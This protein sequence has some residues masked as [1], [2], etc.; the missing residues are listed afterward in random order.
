MRPVRTTITATIVWGTAVVVAASSATAVTSSAARSDGGPSGKRVLA[1]AGAPFQIARARGT[2]FWTD[3]SDQTINR[4][5]KRGPVVAFDF[6]LADSVAGVEFSRNGRTMAVAHGGLST[7]LPARVS[8]VRR[9]KPAIHANLD[10]YEKNVNPDRNRT[11][12]IVSAGATPECKE[13]IAR[14]M[15][16]PA[17]YKGIK[18]SNPH[19]L[20]RL[21]GGAFAVADSGAN[22]ILR[23][24]RAGRISTI[25]LL[26][27]QPVRLTQAH[28]NALDSPDC[29]GVTYAFE[30]V[31]TDVEVGRRGVLWV[32][33][34]PGGTESADGGARGGLYRIKNGVVT[35]MAGGFLGATN[36]ALAG[37]RFYVT[38]F[39]GGKVTMLGQGTRATRYWISQAV[40]I[41]ATRKHLYVGTGVIGV[42]G[43]ILRL[44]R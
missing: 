33:T 41:E 28:A 15:G 7:R 12:G 17:T 44:R 19:Q 10:Q 38:E 35:R 26:P 34:L 37:G 40:S 4:L 16:V 2:I 24:S 22:A 21:P 25:A 13:Q 18:D 30:P 20:A 6:S 31:P 8:L 3:G 29:A 9:G 42:V 32:T 39:F 11:Y 23:V 14:R 5:T 1:A 43:D 36:L 27:P